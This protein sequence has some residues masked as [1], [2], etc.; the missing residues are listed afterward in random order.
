MHELQYV[1]QHKTS[2]LYDWSAIFTE[3]SMRDIST[4][5]YEDAEERL[6]EV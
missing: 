2:N 1:P 3:M 4:R 6:W 5:K